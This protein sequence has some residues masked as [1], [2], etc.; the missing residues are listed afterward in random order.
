MTQLTTAE[1]S[2][3]NKCLQIMIFISGLIVAVFI[4]SMNTGFTK[5]APLDVIR[6]LL[7]SG[8]KAQSLILFEFR[9]PRILISILAGAGLA[10]SGCI[11]QSVTRSPLADPGILGINAGAGLSIVLFI[12][13]FQS[14]Q[15]VPVFTLPIVALIGAAAA[16]VLIYV[17]TL[18]R[19]QGFSST[20][21]LLTGIA[22][23]SGISALMVILTLKFDPNQYQFVSTWLAGTIWGSNW[24]FV[25]A[26]LPWILVIF[27][28]VL[29]HTR[30]L[31]IL[32][33][34]ESIAIGLGVP[35][36]KNRRRLLLAAVALAAACVAVSGGIGFI[37]LIA[38]HL[39]RRL[40]GAQH[41]KLLPVSALTGALLLLAADTLGRWMLQPAE[42]PAGIIVSV[43]GAPYFL[44]LLAH[45]K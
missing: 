10:V 8:T 12:S 20:R 24:H 42:L 23:A 28:Y 34:G 27:S 25:L 29:Y 36:E 38:P 41:L 9:M 15:A 45:A 14:Q 18:K 22:V 40:V 4:I 43:I 39:A 2:K 32:K 13:F 5:L 21:L 35:I 26:L 1:R 31:D 16:A 37:G 17:L 7:G 3:R 30:T 33:L 6:T 19:Q 11:I 44:Y